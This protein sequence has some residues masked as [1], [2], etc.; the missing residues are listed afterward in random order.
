MSG[1]RINQ[2]HLNEAFS[3]IEDEISEQFEDN[4]YYRDW[5]NFYLFHDKLKRKN[6]LQRIL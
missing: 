1:G 2:E 4:L 5:S 6:I 3:W